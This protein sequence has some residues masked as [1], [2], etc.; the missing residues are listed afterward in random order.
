MNVLERF[1][2]S[3][4][5]A[6]RI[7]GR[8]VGGYDISPGRN[9]KPAG[10]ETVFCNATVVTIFTRGSSG[11]F[12][13]CG[14]T[15]RGDIYGFSSIIIIVV[16]AFFGGLLRSVMLGFRQGMQVEERTK[17]CLHSILESLQNMVLECFLLLTLS[18][19]LARESRH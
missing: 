6:A 12:F 5:Q 3:R 13:L 7:E 1:A 10:G 14:G 16:H 17:F 4:G 11:C 15:H 9:G 18:V 2:S 8:K 19:F